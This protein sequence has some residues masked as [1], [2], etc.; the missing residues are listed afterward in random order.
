MTT[1][2][3]TKLAAFG[4][5]LM[6]NSA[7]I[8]GVAYLFSGRLDQPSATTLLVHGPAHTSASAPKWVPTL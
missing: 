2:F 4:V 7:M 1:Q 3:A 5:A 8:G 6:I